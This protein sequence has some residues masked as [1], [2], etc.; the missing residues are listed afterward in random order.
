M[1]RLEE[2]ACMWTEMTVSRSTTCPQTTG[3]QQRML[4]VT[5]VYRSQ[6]IHIILESYSNSECNQTPVRLTMDKRGS[7]EK[8]NQIKI[9]R[10]DCSI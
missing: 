6:E 10:Q 7:P 8:L 2:Q 5:G 4:L 1:A 3:A 9:R